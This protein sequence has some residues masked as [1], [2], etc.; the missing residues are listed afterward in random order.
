MAAQKGKAKVGETS[1]A[2][3]ATRA[4]VYDLPEVAPHSEG[5]ATPPLV[6][7]GAGPSAVPE[8]RVPAPEAPA[9]QPGAE[10]RTLREA[11]QLLTTIVAGQA[12]RRGRRDDDDEDRRDSLRVRE[13]LLCGPP[14]FFGSKPDEDPHD[15][16]RGMRRA[17][18]LVRASETESVELASHR[19]RD[20]AAR[21]YETWELSR[22][23]GAPPA[24]WDQFVTA[25]TRHFLPPELR[26]ERADRFLHL[27]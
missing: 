9:P 21:W 1:Q 8:V 4:R 2:Q 6:Q 24:M 23:E 18:D 20:V 27:Q 13:F 3:R 22:G 19:L 16:I 12:R 11:V 14:E 26:R 7:P 15:F 17:L 10:D 25:F 5:S